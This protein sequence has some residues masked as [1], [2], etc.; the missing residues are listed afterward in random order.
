[1]LKINLDF[2]LYL[3]KWNENFK[4]MSSIL[5]V[6]LSAVLVLLCIAACCIYLAY[7]HQDQE[8]GSSLLNILHAHLAVVIPVP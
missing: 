7:M 2:L 8:S 4:E 5:L 3:M 1:M 6:I